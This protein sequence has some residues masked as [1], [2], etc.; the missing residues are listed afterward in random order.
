[1][2]VNITHFHLVHGFLG[3]S[4]DWQA[5]FPGEP[6]HNLFIDKS[7]LKY[8]TMTQ[9]ARDFNQ[10]I[11]SNNNNVLVGY[12]LGGRLALHALLEKPS[13]WKAVV[14]ISSH[15]GLKDREECGSRLKSDE[16]WAKR[17]EYDKFEDVITAWNSQ[18]V[19]ATGTTTPKRLLHRLDKESL[20]WALKYFSLG[21]QA[22][23]LPQIQTCEVP[24]LWVVGENDV[25][26][27]ELT[28]NLDFRNPLSRIC[29]VPKAGHRVIFDQ[30]IFLRNTINCFL[31]TLEVPNDNTTTR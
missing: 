20:V 18:P 14:I 22:Y 3:E 21:Y 9:W 4:T 26:F 25:K 10:T 2:D 28:K 29:I 8:H 13:L 5:A 19:L 24:I 15:Y 1:M 27:V 7:L 16:L 23:L 31:N 12:S 6:A 30:P 11:D 17:F